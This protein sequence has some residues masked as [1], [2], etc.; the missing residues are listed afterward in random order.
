MARELTH[1]ER[2]RLGAL[3]R[4]LYDA[5]VG[6]V[7]PALEGRL[8]DGS[9]A[10]NTGDGTPDA[11]R[12]LGLSEVD[13]AHLERA[14]PR[15]VRVYQ[16]LV[17]TNL[18][19]AIT[20]QLP[21][22]TALGGA[23]LA[24]VVDEFLCRELPRSPILRDVAFEFARFALP[25]LAANPRLPAFL[26]EL[27]RYELFELEVHWAP[28]TWRARDFEAPAAL[29]TVLLADRPVAFDG[30]CRLGRFDY[31][32][33]ELADAPSSTSAPR[34]EHTVLFAYR[35][36]REAFRRM[37][38]TPV[39]AEL[40][41]RLMHERQPLATALRDACAGHRRAVDAELIDGTS[42]VLA[43]LAERGAVLGADLTEAGEPTH[44]LSPW[45]RW[46]HDPRTA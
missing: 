42:Q 32:V 24:T 38:L 44:A 2:A 21:A 31:A 45:Q 43:E 19:E 46:L 16:K 30:S 18:R 28:R 34:A 41:A 11:E 27:A 20:I 37:T 4:W 26:G 13:R 5:I 17:R 10:R 25:R 35:D 6:R 9:D 22:T 23:G 8:A 39:A 40:I 33:H 3:E 14:D 15:R 7:P 1:D 29:G 12:N 36:S